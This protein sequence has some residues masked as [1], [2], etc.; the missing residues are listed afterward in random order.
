MTASPWRAVLVSFIAVAVTSLTSCF[1]TSGLSE[2]DRNVVR[3]L[4]ENAG[5]ED[6]YYAGSGF[7]V[8]PGYVVTNHHVIADGDRV[9]VVASGSSGIGVEPAR[10]LWASADQ[11][12]AVLEVSGLSRRGLRLGLDDLSR[13]KGERV[14][15]VGFPGIADDIVVM[16][17]GNPD[18]Y[19]ERWARALGE[20]T[21]SSGVV[22]RVIDRPWLGGSIDV[23]MIQHDASLHEGNSGGPL[24]NT[25][26]QVIGV[27]TERAVPVMDEERGVIRP[28]EGMAFAAHASE[29][30][31]VLQILNVPHRTTQRACSSQEGLFTVLLGFLAILLAGLAG[32]VV[33]RSRSAERLK[34]SAVMPSQNPRAHES[35]FLDGQPYAKAPVSSAR[36]AESGW[37]VVWR[38]REAEGQVATD[39]ARLASAEGCV[40]GRSDAVSDLVVEQGTVS[41][42][43]CVLRRFGEQLEV[44]DLN[45]SNGTMISDVRLTPF[46]WHPVAENQP[47]QIGELTLLVCRR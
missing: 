27:N 39:P 22:G 13:A 17:L 20:S 26:G 40:L 32:L 2:V 9:L 19:D 41:R 7:V 31:S 5:G 34:A 18:V 24:L 8:S 12:L 30:A 4:A 46:T 36:P 37:V 47:W 1:G 35:G 3:V 14:L 10:L 28:G 23:R 38:G 25:C 6:G 16:L 15:A 21:V 29:L 33:V 44:M 11:D 43:H 42:R 45:S